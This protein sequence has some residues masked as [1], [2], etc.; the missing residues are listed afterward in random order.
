MLVLV[1]NTMLAMVLAVKKETGE[2][3]TF[4]EHQNPQT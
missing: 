1:E 3:A 2:Q 4:G